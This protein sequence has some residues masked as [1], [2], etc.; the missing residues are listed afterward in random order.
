VTLPSGWSIDY[1]QDDSSYAIR[2]GDPLSAR[3]ERVMV[4]RFSWPGHEVVLSLNTTMTGDAEN[5]TVHR[6]CAA[7]LDHRLHFREETTGVVPRGL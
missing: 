6:E 4:Q 2:D 1:Q 5:F 3:M 7:L